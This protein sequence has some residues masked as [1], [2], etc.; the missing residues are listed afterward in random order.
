MLKAE[1]LRPSHNSCD[2]V[3]CRLPPLPASDLDTI[4]MTNAPLFAIV[5]VQNVHNAL[6]AGDAI[7]K[8]VISISEAR[9]KLLSIVK[10]LRDS[11]DMICQVT[12]HNDVVA[13]IKT[14]PMVKPGEAVA[15]LLALRKR[16]R[17]KAKSKKYSI[18]E[19]IKGH[20]TAEEC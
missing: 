4:R 16:T 6:S 10:R 19:N 8:T 18:S 14:S 7:M 11:P 12:V 20:L 3:V 5:I 2:V 17:K 1:K 9:K 15:K 13:E